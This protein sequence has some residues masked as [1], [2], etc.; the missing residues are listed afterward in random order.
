MQ[1]I[2]KEKIELHLKLGRNLCQFVKIGTYF[3][4]RTFDWIKLEK[5]GDQYCATLVRSFDQGNEVFCDVLEFETANEL[6]EDED[7]QFKGEKEAVFEWLKNEFD[8]NLEQFHAPKHLKEKYLE[9]I[10]NN[11]VGMS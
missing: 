9:L 7:L 2:P 4:D 11:Q 5:E 6:D 3:E 8:I 10:E 1:Y